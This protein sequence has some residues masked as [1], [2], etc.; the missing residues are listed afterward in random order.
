MKKINKS[1]IAVFAALGL[2]FTATPAVNAET[3]DAPVVAIIDSGF[4]TSQL[5]DSVI[6]EACVVAFWGCGT[7]AVQ[8]GPGTSGTTNQIKARYLKDWQHG[9]DMALAMLEVNPNTK[10]VLIRNAKVYGN[11]VAMGSKKDF[12]AALQWVED[13]AEQYGIDA[14]SFSRGSH[15]YVSRGGGDTRVFERI[16][17]RYERLIEIYTRVGI[18]GPIIDRFESMIK[19][20]ED[21]IAAAG[22]I[23]CPAPAET[24]QN[25]K[26][27]LSVGIPTFI[28]AGNN[29][30][31]RYIDTPACLDSAVAVSASDNTGE[32]LKASN[33]SATLTDYIVAAPNTSTATARMAAMWASNSFSA[34]PYED[35]NA[36][37]VTD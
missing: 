18:T 19:K 24:D 25:I 32:L 28:A 26:D 11:V 4:D 14:V 17:S 7:Q 16:I 21:R 36:L 1:L 37:L 12:T 9:T 5:G 2:V 20:Y 10:F 23:E 27:L 22:N 6:Q 30:S 15:T 13:N 29:S 8:V 3:S 35:S 34:S 31:K 33:F